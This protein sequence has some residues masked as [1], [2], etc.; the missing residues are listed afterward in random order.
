[1][2][3]DLQ[4]CGAPKFSGLSGLIKMARYRADLN[5]TQREDKAFDDQ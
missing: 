2:I 3:S 5:A 4:L 1:M